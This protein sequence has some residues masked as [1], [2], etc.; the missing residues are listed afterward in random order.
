MGKVV[1]DGS[2]CRAG[3][4]RAR[5]APRGESV[6]RIGQDGLV[7]F[8]SLAPGHYTVDVYCEQALP[9]GEPLDVVRGMYERE[10]HVQTGLLVH[11]KVIDASGRPLPDAGIALRP[12]TNLD[13]QVRVCSSDTEGLFSCGGLEPGEYDAVVVVPLDAAAEAVTVVL[14][15]NV[16]P[17]LLLRAR[18]F[19]SIRAAVR[20]E[21]A[22]LFRV[23]ARGPSAFPI[24]AKRDDRGFVFERLPLARYE[25]YIDQP[26]AGGAAQIVDLEHEGQVVTLDLPAPRAAVITGFVV[27]DGGSPLPD[28][29]VNASPSDPLAQND[30][31][32]EPE[33][34]TDERGAFGLHVVAGGT[35][36]RST[37]WVLESCWV[38]RPAR[39][40]SWC[41]L[42]PV[43]WRR[44]GSNNELD[45]LGRGWAA[46]AK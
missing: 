17:E 36:G 4:V 30:L 37:P 5:R 23:L 43:S 41:A 15:G 6:A 7:H 29:W 12:R 27:D 16:T 14:D 1:R 33:V 2:A 25:V 10:W 39:A 40:V 24:E 35:F 11:G 34:L 9:H 22:R 8:P 18:P 20:S 32:N 26:S 45:T 42:R 38:W 19:G 3:E 28:S 13:R 31:T 44:G 21:S 46:P